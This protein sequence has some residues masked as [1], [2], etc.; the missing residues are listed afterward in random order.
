MESL[1][2]PSIENGKHV[3]VIVRGATIYD[4]TGQAPY[5]GDVA[6]CGDRITELGDLSSYTAE[7][8]IEAKGSSLAPGFIDVHTHDDLYVLKQPEMECKISQGVTTVIV[9]NC[10]ISASPVVLNAAPPDP[11]NLLGEAAEFR[12]LKFSDYA[13]AVDECGPSVN[14]AALVGHTSLRNNVMT[15]LNRA[16]SPREIEEMRVQ[17]DCALSEGALG[18]SSGLAYSSAI[19]APTYEVADLAKVLGEHG[20]IYTSHLRNEFDEIITAMEEAFYVGESANAS[21]IISHFKCAGAG[22]WGKT[23]QTIPLL[24]Q[25]ATHR[26]V[27]CDCYPYAA[28]SSTLDVGQVTDEYDIFITW[29]DTHPEQSQRMLKEIAA[30][31]GLS[32]FECAAKL[33]PAGAVYHN[34]D[35][36]D[37]RRVL[38][39]KESMIGS[40]GLPNDPHPHPRLWGTFPRVLG[41]YARELELFDLATAI[42]KMTGLSAQ[43]FKLEDRGLIKKGFYADFVLFDAYKINDQATYEEPF[44]EASGIYSVWVNGICAHDLERRAPGRSGRFL[45]R[46][47]SQKLNQKIGAAYA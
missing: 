16:A 41:R 18:L 38:K 8:E 14:V 25:T 27:A 31:W 12:Y 35:E 32:L 30:E 15:C 36:D 13:E 43:K 5:V 10:G 6:I 1:I 33:Q 21:V 37:V 40:D 3:D 28:S 22:N 47:E 45:R 4:G 19:S 26:E 42:W 20:G 17:L 39:Y 11:M 7:K 24:E 46:R 9:G 34:M 44:R 29:S 23:K 2:T